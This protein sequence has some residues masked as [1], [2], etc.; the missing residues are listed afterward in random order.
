[1]SEFSPIIHRFEGE[2]RKEVDS[3]VILGFEPQNGISQNQWM[4]YNT[5]VSV[6][7]RYA[8]L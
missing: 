1:M 4:I 6:G 7:H 5:V 2:K 3:L 8:M